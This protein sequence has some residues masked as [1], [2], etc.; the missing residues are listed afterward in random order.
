MRVREVE[1]RDTGGRPHGKRLGDVHADLLAVHQL[2]HLFLDGVLGT[3]RIAGCRTDAGVGL[4]DEFV[5]GELLVR[6]VAPQVLAHA[7]VQGF[8]KG[9]GQTVGNA[10]E[11]DG[12]VVVQRR[13]VFGF[14]LVGTDAGRDGEHADVVLNAAGLAVDELGRDVVG[15]GLVGDAFTLGVLLT[16]VA[17]G[18]GHLG[19]RVV[20]V[21]LDV[22]VVDGVGRQEHH[23]AV[24]G[25]PAVVDDLLQHGL[26]VGEDLAG[27][28]THHGVIEDVRELAGQVPGLE[29]R[30][31][32]DV[33]GQLGQIL[34]LEGSAANELGPGRHVG[35]PVGLLAV[36]PGI[37]QRNEVGAF[38]LAVQVAHAIVFA[39]QVGQEAFALLFGHQG[40][41]HGHGTRGVGHV[42]DRTGVVGRDLD[43]GVHTRRGGTT[44]QQRNLAGAEVFVTLHLAGHEG[45]FFQRRGDEA[46]QADEVG[47]GLAGL[48]EDLGAGHHHAH[49][50]DLEVVAFEHDGDDVLTDVVH[51][52][53]DG[54]DDDLSARAH[55]AT[56][57]SQSSFLGLDEGQQVSHGLFHDAGGLDHLRQEHLAFTEQ[58]TD[59]VHAGHQRTFDDFD[60]TTA[61][62]RDFLPDLFGVLD[63]VLGDAMH[64]GV[65]DAFLHA[66][67]APGLVG[68]LLAAVVLQGLGNLDE[69]LGGGQFALGGVG[70]QVI[71]EDGLAIE[72]H[73]L[74]TVAQFQRHFVVDAH[75]AGVDDAHGEAGLDGVIEEDRVDGLARGVVAA[76]REGDVGDAARDAGMRQVV[77]NPLAGTDEVV[78]VFVVLFD[79]GGDREDVGIE[80]DVFGREA[81][82]VHQQVVGALAD[83]DLA[84]EGVGLALFVE[85]HDDGGSTIAA[86]QARLVQEL[87]FAFLQRDG[88]DHRLA[89]HAA[90][91][92]L[93]DIPLGAV[94]HDGHAGDVGFTG[95]EV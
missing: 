81:H 79:A 19:A 42:D 6:S 75:H 21:D 91:A 88:V 11:G 67:L 56:G 25:E 40:L 26:A 41:G 27:L 63:D 34:V 51:V 14:L 64:H 46:G 59:D 89:L 30:A 65:R 78:A 61:A 8:G 80:D 54:G 43:G 18:H 5:V 47:T 4:G 62:R 37:G 20:G 3:G 15:Q 82:F 33:F 71:G 72:H 66:A 36:G 38:L 7:L 28:F 70:G 77:V 93:D 83:L 85:G 17:P 31:P 16:Q 13:H 32:V 10:L 90:Q 44:D 39:V 76:E 2:E 50:D 22:V 9:F 1:A 58:V 57:C 29:E 49:V 73:V 74:D 92:G 23:D 69:P 60:G 45:H 68:F 87:G 86:H 48:F 52:P 24:S 95:D 53:L 35:A 84:L 55:V 12:V 94:D